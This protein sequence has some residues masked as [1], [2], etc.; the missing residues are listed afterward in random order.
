[1]AALAVSEVVDENMANAARVHAVEQ[2]KDVAARAMVAFGGAAPLHAC[3]IADKLAIDR[4]I[5]PSGAGVGSAIGFLDAPVSYEIVRSRYARLD[6]FEPG[7]L[8]ALLDAMQAEATA[9]VRAGVPDAP[10]EE[11]RL[12]AM[13]YVGQGHEITVDV[14]VRPLVAGD[15]GALQAAFDA[16]YAALYGRTI[17]GMTVEILTWSLTVSGPEPPLAP[18]PAAAGIPAPEP[19]GRRAVTDPARAEREDLPVY[20]RRDLTTGMVLDGPALVVEDQTTT[21]VGAGFT[22]TCNAHGHLDLRRRTGRKEASS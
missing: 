6:A 18:L 22:L 3:R 20:R 7:S 17:P 4:I 15:A 21:L 9:I 13:R 5:V 12:A 14:P 11:T 19:V 8:N 10:L 16:A 1:M 2:G